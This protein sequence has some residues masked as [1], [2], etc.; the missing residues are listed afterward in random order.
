MQYEFMY[1]ASGLGNLN[2]EIIEKLGNLGIMLVISTVIVFFV[3]KVLSVLLQQNEQ[4]VSSI[5]PRIN[6]VVDLISEVKRDI[7]EVISAHNLSSNKQ[8]FEASTRL[9]ALQAQI[10]TMESQLQDAELGISDIIAQI[11]LLTYA[12]DNITPADVSA[13][14]REREANLARLH[15]RDDEYIIDD[16]MEYDESDP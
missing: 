1:V 15:S 3:I 11:R 12:I 10:K 7:V 9:D 5:L 14:F 6:V 13:K 16:P 8:F 2:P 4:T